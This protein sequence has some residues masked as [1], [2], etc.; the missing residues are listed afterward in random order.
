M[1]VAAVAVNLETLRTT[2]A[3]AASASGRDAAQIDLIAVSKRMPGSMIRAAVA[4]GQRAFG[5]NYLSE[6]LEK[7]SELSDLAIEWHFIGRIQ[8]NKTAEI[9]NAF[10]WV[11]TI[12]RQKIARRLNHQR[13]LDE[14]LNVLLQV[15]ISGEQSK[16][17]VAPAELN[18]L[19][20]A[21]AAL[22]KL[23]L[24]GL[25]ALPAPETDPQAQK[26]AFLSV[27]ALAHKLPLKTDTLSMGTSNDFAA[28]IAAGATMIRVGTAVFGPRPQTP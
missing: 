17:G 14:P 9:A 28:A 25:M 11:H 21:V 10:D 3:G 27:Q 1:S 2:I 6:A 24:R 19:A 8:S 20:E 18:Q 7:Q 23:R 22:P 13:E 4:A 16:G 26:A 12:E 5:E 15:N